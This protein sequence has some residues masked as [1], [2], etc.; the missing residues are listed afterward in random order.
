[1][2]KTILALSAMILFT[3]SIAYASENQPEVNRESK[4]IAAF[5]INALCKAIIK[6]DINVVRELIAQ[7]EDVNRKSLGKTPAHFAARYNKPEILQLLIANGANI[8]ARCDKGY[9]VKK[10]AEL[11]N[12][13]EALEV[14]KSAMKR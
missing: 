1:M 5:E 3:G 4:V 2:K 13:K 12:S 7:G 6:G 9:T 11:S 14:I 10:H 8:K